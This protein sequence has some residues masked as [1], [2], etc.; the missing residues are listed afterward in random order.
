MMVLPR[1]RK[2]DVLRFKN[3]AHT[4]TANPREP[5]GGPEELQARAGGYPKCISSGAAFMGSRP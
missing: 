1:P 4:R 3:I 5:D 2:A